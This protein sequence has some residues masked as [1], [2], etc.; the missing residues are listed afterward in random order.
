M[1]PD[2]LRRADPNPVVILVEYSDG[3]HAAAY[4][5]RVPLVRDEFCFAARVKNVADPV[6][7]WFHLNKPQRDHFSFLCNHIEVMFRSGKPSYPV[8][9]TYLVTGILAA[10][11]DSRAKQHTRLETEHL[12]ELGYHAAHDSNFK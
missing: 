2:A 12:R 8:E 5:S 1:N 9:R 4:L 11:A 10:A 6:A 7:T 3:F